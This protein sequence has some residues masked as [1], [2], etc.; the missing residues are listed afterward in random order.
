MGTLRGVL[1]F[2]KCP[3]RSRSS[4]GFTPTLVVFHRFLGRF[5]QGLLPGITIGGSASLMSRVTSMTARLPMPPSPR[6]R[7]SRRGRVWCRGAERHGQGSGT[8]ALS[9]SNQLAGSVHFAHATLANLG[10]DFVDAAAGA[11]GEGHGYGAGTRSL[12]SSRAVAKEQ[13]RA[14][15]RPDGFSSPLR[16]DRTHRVAVPGQHPQIAVLTGAGRPIEGQPRA[17]G[18]PRTGLSP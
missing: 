14:V 7:G 18:S 6:A 2:K 12:T 9:S 11:G 17:V 3:P 15:T 10:G 16:G 1:L 13:L 4:D 8:R 5:G